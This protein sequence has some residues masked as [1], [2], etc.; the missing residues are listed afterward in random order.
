[1]FSVVDGMLIYQDQYI[2]DWNDHPEDA[3]LGGKNN[4]NMIGYLEDEE[5]TTVKFKI[6]IN[7]G[8]S[9]DAI[10]RADQDFWLLL[11]YSAE[12]NFNHHSTVRK[13]IPYRFIYQE[14]FSEGR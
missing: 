8:D 7:S 12:Y 13:Q 4:I 10:H 14:S 9:M 11:A 2:R 3:A 5:S 1:M 6:P